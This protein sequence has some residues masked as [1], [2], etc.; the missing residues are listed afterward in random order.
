MEGGF[1][2]PGEP[3]NNWYEW[4]AAGR[5]EP[6]GIALDFWNEYERHLDKAA[7]LGVNSF[8]LSVEWARCEP[9]E[10]NYDEEAFARYGA[11]LAGCR[12]RGM[13]PLVTILHF[14]HP[15]WLGVDF[16]TRADAVERFAEWAGEAV[17]RLS[18]GCS[19]WVTLN[20]PNTFALLTFF[21]GACP[22]GRYFDGPTMMKAADL[23]LSAHIAAYGRLKEIQPESVVGTN[24]GSF[25]V[26]ELD[27]LFSDVLLARGRGITRDGLASHLRERRS[28]WYATEAAQRATRS[29]TG[30][31]PPL[32]Q[33][34]RRLCGLVDPLRS[35][36]RT[37][38]GVYASP[39]ERC[40]DV[41][42]LDYYDPSTA[43]HLQ[44]PFG[45][46]VGG[47]WLPPWRP[48]WEDPP[49]PEGLT[50]YCAA[51]GDAGLGVWIVE[52][53]L[54]NRV[55]RGRSYPRRDGW[56]RPR[57][58][59]EN[60][61]AVVDAVSAGVPVSGYWHWSLT[62]NYEWGTYEPRF[63]L[64]GVDRER[65]CRWRRE[66]SMGVDSAGTYRRIIE[67]LKAGDASVLKGAPSR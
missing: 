32:E 64:Y 46:T 57:Y 36:S 61:A 67:G 65:G 21:L 11:I 5:V 37:I 3:R 1:N 51:K 59:R 66:D 47:Y 55:R 50:A 43:A 8:R 4:E 20:E 16:W 12:Q 58:L 56:D 42:Q 62:D 6:S 53:G 40:L 2:G 34:L 60:L 22:P 52:N 29:G 44:L 7:A 48:M 54:C 41:V 31:L 19:S 30:R 28:V 18:P 49:D 24:L 45:R 27:R 63:G 38:E 13:E 26:Y 15:A 25:S 9:T 17:R 10:G 23:L 35:L 33:S 14:T 39:H